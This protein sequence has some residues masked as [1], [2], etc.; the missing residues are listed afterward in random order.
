M[1]EMMVFDQF[2]NPPE[3]WMKA[4]ENRRIEYFT[5]IADMNAPPTKKGKKKAKE[6]EENAKKEANGVINLRATPRTTQPPTTRRLATTRKPTTAAHWAQ[7]VTTTRKP[8]TKKPTTRAPVR[9]QFGN[10]LGSRLEGRP[11]GAQKQQQP[12]MQRMMA[13]RQ[14]RM[15]AAA[16][17]KTTQ[18][19]KVLKTTPKPTKTK[20][21]TDDDFLNLL[22]I[23]GKKE[24]KK[25]EN[26]QMRFSLNVNENGEVNQMYGKDAEKKNT[27]VAS[28]LGKPVNSAPVKGSHV[29][30]R[31][32][33]VQK[34]EVDKSKFGPAST[35]QAPTKAP[36]PAATTKPGPWAHLPPWK[37]R[38]LKAA[39]ARQMAARQN[40]GGAKPTQ[41]PAI[42]ATPK[43]VARK[44]VQPV[45][46]P[47]Q[48]MRRPGQPGPPMRPPGQPMRKPIQKAPLRRTP[49]RAPVPSGKKAKTTKP[50]AARPQMMKFSQWAEPT[51]AKLEEGEI[52]QIN[53]DVSDDQFAAMIA[54]MDTKSEDVD[55]DSL[56]DDIQNEFTDATFSG[57]D[58]RYRMTDE[59]FDDFVSQL[60]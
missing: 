51:D 60:S 39:R 1:R 37:Q 55:F 4:A 10:T 38:Q 22:D 29:I 56:I 6:G 34:D 8:A 48:P 57:P 28:R 44:P 16:A 47:G 58:P 18:K 21:I 5:N 35:K 33:F 32:Q 50:S 59:E 25:T 31:N 2:K 41:K 19:P 40:A 15:K 36:A 45:R 27:N 9:A 13:M 54:G 11:A 26:N 42:K 14:A 20:Q 17:A 52:I 23:L 53:S 3:H 46:K 43:P 12:N 24:T 7:K 49:V 30:N